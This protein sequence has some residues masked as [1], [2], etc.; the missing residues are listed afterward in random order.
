MKALIF[1]A[2]K[3]AVPIF[4]LTTLTIAVS[5]PVSAARRARGL[6]GAYQFLS[7]QVK[8]IGLVDS[9]KDVFNTSYTYDNALAAIA[10]VAQDDYD[11]AKTLLN[12]YQNKIG[13][14]NYGGYNDVYDYQTGVGTGYISAGPNAWLL[15]AVNFYYYNT[16]DP[17][18]LTLAQ[19]LADFLVGLQD[20]D[21][22]VFGDRYVTWKST[23]QNLIGYASLY[24]FGILTQQDLYV[25][26]ANLIKDF[27]VRECWNGERFLRGKNDPTEVTDVQAAGVLALGTVYASSIYWAEYH[28]KCA[29]PLGGQTVTGFDFNNDLD[30]VWLEGTLQETLAFKKNF[31]DYRAGIYYNNVNKTQRENGSFLCATNQGTTGSDWVLLPI[32]SVAPTCWYIF[33][34]TGTNPF[35]R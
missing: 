16:N 24:N 28:T 32:E 10:F 25:Q 5:Q 7:N 1:K 29:K 34:K 22:G 19:K 11:R 18:F 12:A 13:L 6:E 15:N 21:G 2:A 9:Y 8:G 30:T 17:Q 4:L 23:E 35:M 3:T 33:Y 26:K 31:D 27:L 20:T 14:P